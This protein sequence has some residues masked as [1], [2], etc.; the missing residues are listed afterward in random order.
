M[1]QYDLWFAYQ[2]QKCGVKANAVLPPESTW[3]ARY[4]SQE[5]AEG[6]LKREGLIPNDGILPPDGGPLR[7]LLVSDQSLIRAGF[8]HALRGD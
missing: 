4:P 3:E 7:T 2:E 6:T 1:R 8:H 5:A